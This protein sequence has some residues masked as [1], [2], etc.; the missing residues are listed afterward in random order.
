M[1]RSKLLALLGAGAMVL[2]SFALG[3]CPQTGGTADGAVADDSADSTATADES[4]GPQDAA[5]LDEPVTPTDN[6]EDVTDPGKNDSGVVGDFDGDLTL[7]EADIQ[8]L[9]RSFNSNLAGGDLNSDNSVDILD[10]AL[11]LSLVR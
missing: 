3:G 4:G 10:L 8:I 11:L 7:T 6:P 9:A 2:G 5:S 1:G